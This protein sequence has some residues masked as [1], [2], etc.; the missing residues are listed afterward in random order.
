MTGVLRRRHID[1]TEGGIVSQIIAF[2]VPIVLSELLQ[3]LYNSVDSL[4]V[5][6]IIGKG[7]LAAVS[8]CTPISRLVVGFF[9][10]LSVGGSVV[11]GR[12][13]GS[14]DR[15]ELGYVMRG[16]F[17]FSLLLGT[18][19]SLLGALCTP[20]LLHMT[21]V[22]ES[23]YGGAETYLRIYFIGALFTVSYNI[24]AGILR[25]TGD[26]GSPFYI[27]LASCGCNIV[28]DVAFVGAFRWGIAGVAAATVLSQALS[29]VLAV[30]VIRRFDG[31]FVFAPRE[32]QAHGGIIRDLI[33][34]GVP[35]GVQNALTAVSNLMVWR[36]V[37]SFGESAMAGVGVAQRLDRF[38]GMPCTAF[39]H[40]ITT[41]VSQNIGAGNRVRAQKGMRS[42]LLLSVGYVIGM[43]AIVYALSERCVR[44]FNQDPEVVAIGTDMMHLLIPFYFL[45]A[46]RVVYLGAL[47]GYGDSTVPMILTLIGLLGVRQVY[48]SVMMRISHELVHV[49]VGYPVAWAAAT[50]LVMAYYYLTRRRRL[51]RLEKTAKN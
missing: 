26:S 28:L 49:Y 25:A 42:T 41:F 50:A 44:L 1:F 34:I 38:I 47:R 20:L 13:F 46:L 6:N 23:V 48:L 51:E 16:T 33:A 24:C 40:A 35:A 27:L 32:M 4:V 11:T 36:Y 7:A 8:L 29:L 45:M 2:S 18:A 9:N 30:R 31:G 15:E 10:G 43:G 12:A 37:N 3:N 22:P 19:L 39:G 5:G 17:T 21:E 14:H